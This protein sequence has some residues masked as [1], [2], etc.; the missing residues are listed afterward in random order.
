VV[1][2]EVDLQGLEYLGAAFVMGDC[3]GDKQELSS[4][5]RVHDTGRARIT[6][7]VR[8]PAGKAGCLRRLEKQNTGVA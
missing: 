5:T 4:S 8:T 3:R 2:D 7:K 1:G 6:R